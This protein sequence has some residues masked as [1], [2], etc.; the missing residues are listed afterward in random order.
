MQDRTWAI[1]WTVL[2]IGTVTFSAAIVCMGDGTAFAKGPPNGGEEEAGVHNLS[3]PVIFPEGVEPEGFPDNDPWT[4]ASITDVAT[5]CTTGVTPGSSVP[6]NLVCYFADGQVWWLS[7]RQELG[8]FWKSFSIADPTPTT[9]V[10]VTAVDWGDL[11]ESSPSLNLRRIR[12]EVTLFKNAEGDPDFEQFIAT[13]EDMALPFSGSCAVPT[14]DN[15]I[16]CFAAFRMSGAVPGTEQSINELQGTD[17]GINVPGGGQGHATATGTLVDPT[18]VRSTDTVVN[19]DG[20]T[21]T[22]TDPLGFHATVFTPCARFFIQRIEGDPDA[23][24][25][26]EENHRWTS[27]N[28]LPVLDVSAWQGTYSTEINATGTLIHGL[29]WDASNQT[30]GTYRLTY[31]IDA[32]GPDPEGH[33]CT[34]VSNTVFTEET[35]IANPGEATTA[36]L[37]PA[38]DPRLDNDLTVAGLTYLDITLKTKGAGSG[39]KGGGKGGKG[40]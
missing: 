17:F 5:Q 1:T 16:G 20:E 31:L 37:V 30:T 29:N 25:W 27:G 15:Q 38:L 4:F 26:D 3:F 33:H 12:T 14:V 23:V 22:L 21:T 10:V 32:G 19:S 9:P 28:N 40:G 2:C 6:P 39:G 13:P 34:I 18:I 11:L 7:K 8:N 35:L 36:V 24:D